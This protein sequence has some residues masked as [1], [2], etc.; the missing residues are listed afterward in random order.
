MM[1]AGPGP[2]RDIVFLHIPKTA[3]TS[4]RHALAMR[5]GKRAVLLDYGPDPETSPALRDPAVAADLRTHVTAP[6]GMLLAGH[7]PAQRYWG[8]FNPD[9]FVTFLRDPV[10][11]VL[12]EYNHEVTLKGHAGSL[13]DFARQPRQRNRM[14]DYLGEY[15]RQFGFIGLMEEYEAGLAEL[16]RHLG[17]ALPAVRHNEGRYRPDLAAG[18]DAATLE[19]IRE[20]N[21]RDVALHAA[22]RG[23]R[24]PAVPGAAVP[25]GVVRQVE[26]LRFRGWCADQDSSRCWTVSV[27]LEG[28]EVAQLRADRY[29]PPLREKRG[30]RTGI[31]HFVFDAKS[32]AGQRG[33]LDFA[34]AEGVGRIVGGPFEIG[35][36][37]DPAG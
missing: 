2:R 37:A 11:R 18:I 14:S 25:R 23:H 34:V 19:A 20:A 22:V 35:G 4:L 24:G 13:L 3:G 7:F 28:R 26:A 32:L 1:P 30:I 6:H 36:A 10:A 9:S 8:Q 31:G 16:S 17:L 15:W 33:M 29:A 5:A 27:R 12:S 21:A